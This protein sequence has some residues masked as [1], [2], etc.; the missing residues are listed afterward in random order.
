MNTFGRPCT[1]CGSRYHLRFACDKVTEKG[2]YTSKPV[3]A[4]VVYNSARPAQGGSQTPGA[5]A[6]AAPA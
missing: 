5:Q 2:K 6:A 3:N 1:L 4:T